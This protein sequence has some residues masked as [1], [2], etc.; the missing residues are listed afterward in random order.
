MIYA[1]NNGQG[2]MSQ[3]KIFQKPLQKIDE[4]VDEPKVDI[5]KMKKLTGEIKIPVSQKQFSL[6]GSVTQ[7]YYDLR[8][9]LG[10]DGKHDRSKR[11][12]NRKL[13]AVAALIIPV[14][15]I[16]FQEC[17][18]L[19][20]SGSVVATGS[21]I[22]AGVQTQLT[23]SQNIVDA[24]AKGDAAAVSTALEGTA[25]QS[26][27]VT[28]APEPMEA[29]LAPVAQYNAGPA[30]VTVRQPVGRHAPNTKDR[31]ATEEEFWR[32][33]PDLARS[34]RANKYGQ[35]AAPQ[36]A[37]LESSSPAGATYSNAGNSTDATTAAAP[38]N[39][40]APAA[41]PARQV[42]NAHNQMHM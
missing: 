34:V 32:A 6:R 21:A 37:T 42:S 41:T 20:E 2:T 33:H 11:E 40:S 5:R 28:T 35:S 18:K 29:V 17:Q 27:S 24:A 26:G 14:V 39:T 38:S 10:L 23:R 13:L 31:Y 8:F 15:F 12:V 30:P 19:A 36:S 25:G 1:L 9:Y 7:L 16:G 22:S 3:S 4:Y